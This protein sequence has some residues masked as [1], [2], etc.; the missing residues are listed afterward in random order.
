MS[1]ERVWSTFTQK[2]IENRIWQHMK[3]FSFA[4]TTIRLDRFTIIKRNI[5]LHW[6]VAS[7]CKHWVHGLILLDEVVLNSVL[8]FLFQMPNQL[9][10]VKLTVTFNSNLLSV[11]TSSSWIYREQWHKRERERKNEAID[12][13]FILLSGILIESDLFILSAYIHTYNKLSE[14]FRNLTIRL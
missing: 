10:D 3:Y 5:F 1:E 12:L 11:F 6:F 13:M 14:H 9:H 7:I 4:A 8:S 2:Q